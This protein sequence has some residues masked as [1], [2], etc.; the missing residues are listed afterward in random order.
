MI[1][2]YVSG[3]NCVSQLMDG[4]WRKGN[5]QMNVSLVRRSEAAFVNKCLCLSVCYCHKR[6]FHLQLCIRALDR[7][8]WDCQSCEKN[9]SSVA[10]FALTNC[11]GRSARSWELE[12]RI[13]RKP[14]W[15]CDRIGF[16]SFSAAS[17]AR[18]ETTETGY[19][20]WQTGLE[21]HLYLSVSFAFF[22]VI[23]HVKSV[24][25]ERRT[26]CLEYRETER[27]VALKL[28]DSP[29]EGNKWSFLLCFIQPI[30]FGVSQKCTSSVCV[31][32]GN[33]RQVVNI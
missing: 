21:S 12:D 18:Y 11:R 20:C 1:C 15:L 19:S 28:T 3:W 6:L 31:V 23:I 22:H 4:W 26:E 30:A 16:Q 13:N 5:W 2:T 9:F 27:S 29:G 8:P 25:K 10:H 14:C 17:N 33:D 24:D 7:R 32:A